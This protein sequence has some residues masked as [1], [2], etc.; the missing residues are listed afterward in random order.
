MPLLLLRALLLASVAL[1]L[2]GVWWMHGAT[3]AAGSWLLLEPSVREAAVGEDAERLAHW[4]SEAQE[5]RFLAPGLPSF[6][7]DGR[8]PTPDAWS[9]LLEADRLAP[10]GVELRVATRGRLGELLGA[11]PAMSHAV[12]WMVVP[13]IGA[14]RALLAAGPW[15]DGSVRGLVETTTA[16]GSRVTAVNVPTATRRVLPRRPTM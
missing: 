12:S 15:K 4:T 5:V 8:T 10:P 7:P 2:A 11:R 6:S 13:A 1:A 3:A 14:D 9:L 16:Q